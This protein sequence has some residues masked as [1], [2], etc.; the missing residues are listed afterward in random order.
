MTCSLGQGALPSRMPQLSAHQRFPAHGQYSTPLA[1]PHSSPSSRALNRA[2]ACARA[3]DRHPDRNLSG[4]SSRSADQPE[5]SPASAAGGPPSATS[6]RAPLSKRRHFCRLVN[7][8]RVLPQHLGVPSA[9]V[10]WIGASRSAAPRALPPFAIARVG[11]AI[12]PAEHAR[13]PCSEIHSAP[14]RSQ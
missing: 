14:Y 9:H 13:R 7:V 4:H 2:L 11:S 8:A 3:I 12:A 6:Q 5:V 1:F 10:W